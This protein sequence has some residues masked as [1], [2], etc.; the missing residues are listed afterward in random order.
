MHKNANR[1]GKIE[2]GKWKI[3]GMQTRTTT[4]ERKLSKDAKQCT[5]TER[6]HGSWLTDDVEKKDFCQEF[7]ANVMEREGNGKWKTDTATDRCE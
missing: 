5:E 7:L 2:N 3:C 1:K 4:T 6:R